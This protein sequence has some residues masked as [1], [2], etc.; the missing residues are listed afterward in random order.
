[1]PGGPLDALTGV[2]VL[3]LSDDVAGA[4]CAKLFADAG[5]EIVKIEPPAG[6]R[7]RSWSLSGSIGSDGD[8]DG[9]LFRYLAANQRSVVADIT[10]TRGRDRVL[11]LAAISDVVIESFPVGHL[12]ALGLGLTDLQRANPALNLVSITPFGQEGPRRDDARGDLLLQALS[13]SL[14]LH[15]DERGAPLAVGGRLGTWAVG[16]YAAAGALAA[17]CRSQRTGRGEHVDVSRLECLVV[18]LICYPTVSA[19]LPGGT[20]R[21]GIFT[22]V[23]GIEACRDGFVGLSTITVQQWHDFLA[24]IDRA[25]LVE[26]TEWNDQKVRQANVG[27]VA[28]EL[29]P[30]FRDRIASEIVERAALFRIPAAPICNGATIPEL[31]HLVA[32]ELFGAN[33]RGGFPHPRP[34]FR[35]SITEP[36]PVAPAPRLG[37]HDGQVFAP[38]PVVAAGSSTGAPDGP[39]PLEGVRVLDVTAFWAGPFA[40]QYLAT[41]GADVIKVE[42]VQ[43]PD[44]MRFAV[45]VPPTQEH[46]FEYAPL[47]LSVNLNKRGITLD[48]SRPRGRELFLEL[49]ATADVVVENFTPRVMEQFQLTYDV[50]RAVRPDV[51]MLRMPGW[52]LDGPWRDRPGFAATMEQASGMVW[53]TGFADGSPQM[54]GICDPLAG[55]HAAFAVLAALEERRNTGQG[56]EIELSMIDMAVNVAAEQIIEHAA[57]GN[58]VQRDGNRGPTAAPQGVYAC[59]EPDRWVALAVETD[60]EW[61]ALCLAIGRDDLAAD[62]TLAHA[63]GRRRAQDRLDGDL[64]AWC[65]THSRD[66]VLAAWRHAG[67]PAEP[68]VSGYDIDHDAQMLARGFW[69]RVDHPVAGP[70]LYPGWPMRLSGG[71]DRWYRS[72]APLLGQHTEEILGKDLGLG[73]DEL[74]A[75]RDANVIGDRPIG[76]G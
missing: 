66:E 34:P 28:A 8:T 59:E 7:L 68:V 52:G 71:P 75:L 37:E 20:R 54:P 6:H 50:L 46:W 19:A 48:L 60:A 27:E 16:A 72:P 43:R 23:P 38:R 5:A 33:P 61:R 64:S 39:L 69:Q 15:G 74:Q 36:A 18:T 42:S 22:M 32:R 44:P 51:V 2:R 13:G 35:S 40:T 62:P 21:H 70:L 56:Q 63:D 47:F 11:E 55:A 4:Y 73:S 26:R 24:M 30:W 14:D 58:L 41:L 76:R 57:Y 45:S 9:A 53:A 17:R 65:R 29:E 25:D 49:V 10:D 3:D 67:V 31:A 1:M 12:R